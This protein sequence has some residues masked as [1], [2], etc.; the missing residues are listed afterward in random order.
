MAFGFGL[1]HGFGFSL[2]LRD[3]LQFAGSHLISSLL[4]FNVGVEIGQ[5]SVLAVFVFVLRLLFRYVVAERMG[6]II[7]PRLWRTRDG[8]GCSSGRQPY[9]YFVSRH[10]R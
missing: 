6:V 10:A 4:A 9:A 3:S 5:V 7:L 1:V 8:T 2:A